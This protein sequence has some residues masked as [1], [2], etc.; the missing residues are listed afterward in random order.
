MATLQQVEPIYGAIGARVRFM[1]ET[2]GIT[3]D[4]LA[5][6]VGLSRTSLVNFENGKQRCMLHDIDA[7]AK[8]LGSTPKHL[9]RGTWV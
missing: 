3:Q 8:A 9:L 1:R 2:L 6:R 5:K 7:M 4:D